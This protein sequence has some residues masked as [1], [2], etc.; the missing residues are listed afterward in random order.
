MAKK[1]S[2]T[3]HIRQT[4]DL[5]AGSTPEVTRIFHVGAHVYVEVRQHVETS[6]KAIMLMVEEA[7]TNEHEK[8]QIRSD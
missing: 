8:D 1:M 3:I 2:E 4:F 7:L 6:E 5:P